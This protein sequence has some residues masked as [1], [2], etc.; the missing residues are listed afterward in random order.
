MAQ[1][2]VYLVDIFKDVVAAAGTILGMT[3]HYTYGSVDEIRNK[4]NILSKNPDSAMPK[5]PLVALITDTRER[6]GESPV[7]YSNAT[8][9]LLIINLTKQSAVAEDRTTYNFKAVIHPIWEE[10]QN[11]MVKCHKFD[12]DDVTLL[13]YTK[14][15]RYNWGRVQALADGDGSPD[16]IDATDITIDNLPVKKSNCLIYK[17]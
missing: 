14:Y 9:R 17:P 16:F 5:Y 8:V 13:P 15:D 7:L 10:I 1:K 4:L 12:I 2:T 6:C 3:L 11:Q